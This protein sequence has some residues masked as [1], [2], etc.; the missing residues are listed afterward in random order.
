MS[1]MTDVD[2]LIDAIVSKNPMVSRDKLLKRLEEERKKSGGLIS[3][4][5]LLRMVAAEFGVEISHEAFMLST[6]LM[7]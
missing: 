7:A 2:G 5:V 3:D 4:E 1:D 6:P